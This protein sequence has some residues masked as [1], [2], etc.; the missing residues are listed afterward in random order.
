M[1]SINEQ[2]GFAVVGVYRSW[3]LDVTTGSFAQS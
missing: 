2:L 1:I 3:E